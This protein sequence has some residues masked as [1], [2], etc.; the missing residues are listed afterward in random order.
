MKVFV[1]GT[2]GIP[3]VMGG[4]ETHCE[5]LYPR[6]AAKGYDITV[7]SEIMAILCLASDIDDLKARIAR[8]VVGYTYDNRPV[9]A[10]DLPERKGS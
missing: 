8:I 5:N 10:A 3:G 1:T 4:V 9:T 2:R 7:A 6:L